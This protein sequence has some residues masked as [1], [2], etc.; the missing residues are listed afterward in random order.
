MAM[1]GQKRLKHEIV[2]NLNWKIVTLRRGEARSQHSKYK[3]KQKLILSKPNSTCPDELSQ[4][5]LRKSKI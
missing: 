2:E 5:L 3:C 4:Q 1:V